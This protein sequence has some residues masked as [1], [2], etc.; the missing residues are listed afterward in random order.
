MNVEDQQVLPTPEVPVYSVPWKFMDNWIAVGMLALISGALF[1]VAAQGVGTDIIQTAGILL[2]ELVYLL[3]V[4]LIFAW[5]RVHWKVLGFGRFTLETMGIGCGLLIGAYSIII[6]HNVILYFLGVDT[7]GEEIMKIF[8]ELESPVWFF[9]VGVV[10]AP[11]VEEVFFRGFLFQGFRQK[12]GWITAALLSSAIFAVAH[13]DLV[14]LI[15]TF[16]LGVVLAYVYHRSNSVW[17]GVILHFLV[18]AM[19][20]CATYFAIYFQD[21]IPS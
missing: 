5:R 3:P 7:Q 13:M 19:G 9:I 1:I 17:P 11:I 20:F 14:A 2:I 21:S 8:A 4:V 12:Y 15:P 18:N 10:M 6:V 16:I